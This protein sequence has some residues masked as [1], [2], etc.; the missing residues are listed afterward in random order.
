MFVAKN[1]VLR[2]ILML[3]IPKSGG[4]LRFFRCFYG[5]WGVFW[6]FFCCGV[7]ESVFV[8]DEVRPVVWLL[9]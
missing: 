3:K 8:G 5:W 7:G 9:E 2:P 4:F 6:V 1:G